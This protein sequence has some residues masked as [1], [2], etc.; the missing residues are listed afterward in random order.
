MS[1]TESEQSRPKRPLS[2]T[3]LCFLTFM[4][5]FNGLWRQADQL[6]SPG[7][8]A[9][10]YH[11]S[12]DSATQMMEGFF[13]DEESREAS[14]AIIESV[15]GSLTAKTLQTSA[16]IMLIYESLT[17]FGAYYMFQLQRRGFKLYL[18]GIV[19]GL[20]GAIFVLGGLTG[21]F[22]T[23]GSLFFSLIFLLLYRLHLKHMY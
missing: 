8:A 5:A 13:P 14:E 19:V 7:R 21:M 18:A 11:Q 15:R 1:Y 16:I 2:L 12:F 20:L 10:Q 23:S 22:L 17:L 9:D 3:I 4:S 6:W